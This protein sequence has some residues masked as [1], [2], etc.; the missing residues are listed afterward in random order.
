MRGQAVA[1]VAGLPDGQAKILLIGCTRAVNVEQLRLDGIATL[2]LPCT[3]AVP[4]ALLDFMMRR[5]GVDGIFLTGCGDGECFHRMGGRWVEQRLDGTRE[6]YLRTRFSRDRIRLSWAAPADADRL[7][8]EVIDFRERL[9]P[10][11]D[12]DRD[13]VAS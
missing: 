2:D 9:E 6:T 7:L 11:P 13:E 4:P 5:G 1:A 10:I 12:K 8:Q 3:G